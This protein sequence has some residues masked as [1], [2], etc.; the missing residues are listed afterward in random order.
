MKQHLLPVKKCP[1]FVLSK[2]FIIMD[3][4]DYETAADEAGMLFGA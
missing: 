4:D 1:R 2:H 3:N